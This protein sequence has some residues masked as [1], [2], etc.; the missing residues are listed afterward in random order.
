MSEPSH[1]CP[2]PVPAG[3]LAR[4][5]RCP[6]LFPQVPQPLPQVPQPV[7]AGAPARSHRCLSPFPQ[8]PRPIP[9][10][11]PAR[12]RRCLSPLL[13]VPQP[14]PTGAPACSH[15]CTSLLSLPRA[16]ITNWP[17]S[18]LGVWE[19]LLP[20]QIFWILTSTR[21]NVMTTM[22][23]IIIWLEQTDATKR[24]RL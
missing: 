2:Q 9:T 10:G 12:S 16:V 21:V 13:Q 24:A 20:I 1:R 19:L 4:C 15:G 11:A 18:S 5:H 7:P 17:S 8:V 14:V 23:G 6:S 3:A 22:M